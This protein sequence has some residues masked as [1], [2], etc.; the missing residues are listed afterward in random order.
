M[1]LL[2][3]CAKLR[4][5]KALIPYFKFY[6]FNLYLESTQSTIRLLVGYCCLRFALLNLRQN[7]SFFEVWE[8]QSHILGLNANPH[9]TS[10]KRW[11]CLK[12]KVGGF[13]PCV[14]TYNVSVTWAKQ[15]DHISRISSL[16]NSPAFC[17]HKVFT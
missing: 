8:N 7:C 13:P 6:I 17:S 11:R 9:N 5:I 15:Q 14:F 16:I 2:E 1:W 12:L 10:N 4:I 3:Q